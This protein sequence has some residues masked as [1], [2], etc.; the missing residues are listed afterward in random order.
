MSESRLAAFG[1]S[2]F[3][4]VPIDRWDFGQFSVNL[5]IPSSSEV[6]RTHIL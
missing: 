5:R 3:V 4:G 2:R 6:D 1:R